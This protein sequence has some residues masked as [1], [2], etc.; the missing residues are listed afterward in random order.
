MRRGAV[1]GK[2]SVGT[3]YQIGGTQ[4]YC[5][6]GQRRRYSPPIPATQPTLPALWLKNNNFQHEN[7]L[8]TESTTIRG[9]IK[10]SRFIPSG[11]SIPIDSPV[12]RTISM[13]DTQTAAE[14]E[15][16]AKWNAGEYSA[17]GWVN[18]TEGL[19]EE[20]FRGL[21]KYNTE[22]YLSGFDPEKLKVGPP[23]A[24]TPILP[25]IP[26][27][28]GATGPATMSITSTLDSNG[29]P[30]ICAVVTR[31]FGLGFDEFQAVFSNQGFAGRG[32]VKGRVDWETSDDYLSSASG[33]VDLQRISQT[34]KLYLT[35]TL[36]DEPR[37]QFAG[38]DTEDVDITR[39]LRGEGSYK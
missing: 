1:G 15:L 16:I 12:P 27:K 37:L 32:E 31:Y 39:I 29:K 3:K 8:L 5:R 23:A 7:A 14:R 33:P 11:T 38:H 24:G 36:N 26:K 22:K 17:E 4:R 13:A 28:Y 18:N 2:T 10:A 21:A 6:T 35:A 20:A 34:G 30:L 19:T 25:D 9:P